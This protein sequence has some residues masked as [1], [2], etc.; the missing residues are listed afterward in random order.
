MAAA[1]AL[2]AGFALAA[3]LALAAGLTLAAALA[4]AAGFALTAGLA[5]PAGGAAGPELAG[6]APPPH[7]TS[8]TPRTKAPLSQT[9]RN[10]RAIVSFMVRQG[11]TVIV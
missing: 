1:L 8:A 4:L 2:T 3:A 11:I 6:A 5:L 10:R 7:A 9:C